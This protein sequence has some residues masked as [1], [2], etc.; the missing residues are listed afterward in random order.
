MKENKNI[1]RLFQ[2]KFKDFEVAPPEDSW[3]TIASKIEE[4]KKKRRVIPFWFKASGIAASLFIGLFLILNY[5]SNTISNKT[6]EKVVFDNSKEKNEFENLN[7]LETNKSIENKNEVVESDNSIDSKNKTISNEDKLEK[8]NLIKNQEKDAN[9]KNE[10]LVIS[11]K[12]DKPLETYKNKKRST[13]QNILEKENQNLINKS[14]L[15]SNDKENN[16]NKSLKWN[17]TNKN[18]SIIVSKNQQNSSET[19]INE[20]TAEKANLINKEKVIDAFYTNKTNA[21]SEKSKNNKPDIDN[22]INLKSSI[23]RNNTKENKLDNSITENKSVD[24]NSFNKENTTIE[25]TNNKP[26][27]ILNITKSNDGFIKDSTTVV[28]EVETEVNALEQLL[29]EKEEGKNAD[30]KEKEKRSKWVVSSN[31]APVYFNSISNGSPIDE[32]FTSNQ[33]SYAKTLSFGLGLQYAITNKISIRS[34]VN[35]ININYNTNDVYYSSSLGQV[36]ASSLNIAQNSNAQNL[37][38]RGT[39]ES[40]ATILSTDVEN[41]S[42]SSNTASLNQEMGY[43]EIPL[44]LSYKI[45]D[46]KIGIEFIG[47]MSTLLL[48]KNNISLV[49]RGSEMSIGEANNL[50][51]IHFSSNIGLGFNYNFWKSFQLNVQPV[52]KYQ[53]NTFNS[54]S[55]NFKP[56]IIGLYS[57][58]SFKF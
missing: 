16:S 26:N 40:T 43:I 41:L 51:N 3:K 55:G 42:E 50:N 53:I 52:F 13:N 31:A 7:Q 49:S 56:Y 54:N 37:I 27:N 30:E 28:A 6:E 44:E 25:T 46:K 9:S 14:T 45:L 4:K 19:N 34:G 39:P 23:T 21:I 11:T 47:G 22:E 36:N 20:S 17:D 15:V 5:E 32:Q 2:E 18:E 1:E 33:K 8:I 48:N 10:T 24:I 35:S 12:E 57:G 38:L 58:V 29:K